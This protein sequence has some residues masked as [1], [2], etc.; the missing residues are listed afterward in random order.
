MAKKV[1]LPS[2]TVAYVINVL[3]DGTV[4]DSMEGYTIP[5]NEK[6]KR[7]Y[8]MKAQMIVDCIEKYMTEEE[9]KELERSFKQS[10]ERT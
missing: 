8:Q 6:T 9:L 1:V 7:I 5:Y 2:G 3:A 4:R 10:K